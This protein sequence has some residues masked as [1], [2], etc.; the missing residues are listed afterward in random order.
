[1][2]TEHIII[3][4]DDIIDQLVQSEIED[5]DANDEFTE[6]DE[7]SIEAEFEALSDADLVQAYKLYVSE[8][9]EYLLTVEVK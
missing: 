4:R 8:D 2:A 9:P 6:G 1:M 3:S 7:V 5:R